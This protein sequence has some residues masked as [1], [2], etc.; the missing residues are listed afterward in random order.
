MLDPID[1]ALLEN[2]PSRIGPPE[3]PVMGT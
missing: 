1:A 2:T 3:Q